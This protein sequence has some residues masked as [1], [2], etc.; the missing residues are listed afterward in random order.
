MSLNSSFHESNV[1][2]FSRIS[3]TD[4]HRSLSWESGWTVHAKVVEGFN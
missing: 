3:V 1:A 2:H 4:K